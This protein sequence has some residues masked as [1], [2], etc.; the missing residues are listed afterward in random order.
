MALDNGNYQ[1]TAYLN[2]AHIGRRAAEDDSLLPKRIL[3]LSSTP[4]IV[5][6]SLFHLNDSHKL[7]RFRSLQW[8]LESI[9]NDK[10]ILK[11]RGSHTAVIDHLVWAILLPE[12]GPTEWVIT[13]AV[14]KGPNAYM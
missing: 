6:H 4:T 2:G 13:A 1:I 9:G 14:D 12:P 11:A 5:C 8:Q 7:K 10:Y 3:S